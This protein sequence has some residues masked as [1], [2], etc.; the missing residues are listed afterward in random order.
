[1]SLNCPNRLK[2]RTFLTTAI[3]T[4]AAGLPIAPSSA[5]AANYPEHAIT[6]IVPYAP[7][8]GVDTTA[9]VF[10]RQLEKALKQ[11]VVIE[12][13][14]GAGSLIGIGAALRAAP[15]GY[16]LLLADPALAINQNLSPKEPYDARHDLKA[17]SIVTTAPYVLVATNGLDASSPDEVIALSK[18]TKKGLT[19]AS[20]GIGTAPHMTGELLKLKTNSNLIHVPYRGGAP[21]M[22]DLT[23]GQVDLAFTTIASARASLAQGR[24][25]GIATTGKERAPDFPSLP[26]LAETVPGFNV[27]YWTG[28]FAPAKTP[29]EIIKQL[30]E[31]TRLALQSP[32]LSEALKSSGETATYLQIEQSEKFLDNEIRMW[33]DVISQANLKNK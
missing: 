17:I 26:T 9:R 3:C 2:R 27:R 12:N 16:T 29:P 10:V 14:S 7:G 8:G 1:M 19:F 13:R 20:A 28:L 30:N 18:K 32:E 31:A 23:A 25:R 24:I 21:A 4:L 15:D 5:S 33:A 6:L 22:T 11:T